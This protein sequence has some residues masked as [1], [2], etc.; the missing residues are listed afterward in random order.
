MWAKGEKVGP[1]T[2]RDT[3]LQNIT[4]LLVL[5]ASNASASWPGYATYKI[6][7][8]SCGSTILLGIAQYIAKPWHDTGML[9]F[10]F[11]HTATGRSDESRPYPV[12]STLS[13][14]WKPTLEISAAL[15]ITRYHQIFIKCIII[16]GPYSYHLVKVV[17]GGNIRKN[18]WYSCIAS[19]THICYIRIAYQC[20]R[21]ML[22]CF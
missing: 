1:E 2:K 22:L 6:C 13:K 11:S 17:C 4:L 14:S 12:V 10:F 18:Y 8:S 9:L 21:L 15:P 5:L 7:P 16:I 20:G 3:I 19:L